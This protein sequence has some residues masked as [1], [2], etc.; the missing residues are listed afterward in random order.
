MLS[1]CINC[2]FPEVSRLLHVILIWLDTFLL[3]WCRR[4]GERGSSPRHLQDRCFLL[5]IQY[6]ADTTLFRETEVIACAL[7]TEWL[8]LFAFHSPDV[9]LALSL[10]HL[11][12]C[13][14]QV[15]V[16]DI[17]L[18]DI[19]I[20]ICN[21]GP[22]DG[23]DVM[24]LCTVFYELGCSIWLVD[25]IPWEMGCERCLSHGLEVLVK[26]DLTTDRLFVYSCARECVSLTLKKHAR[27]DFLTLSHPTTSSFRGIWTS[28][29][30]WRGN[31]KQFL[32]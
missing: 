14:C 16:L 5:R 22:V 23:R 30:Y 8:L 17:Y 9:V 13:C 26:N 6:A 18:V 2:H 19:S 31:L 3:F 20:A 27:R 11:E 10:L 24:T 15:G 21:L 7:W 1:Y 12:T 29:I 4:R 32:L 28:Q 25:T